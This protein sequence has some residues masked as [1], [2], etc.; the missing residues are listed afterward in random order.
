VLF[1][2]L[3]VGAGL[4]GATVAE[5]LA[6]KYHRRVLVIEARDHV[7]GHC[8]DELDETGTYVHK[9]GPHI[10][11]T[12]NQQVWDYLS[13][14]TDWHLYQH[15]VLA[16]I[17]GKKVPVPF[18]FESMEALFPREIALR[19]E[20]KLVERYGFNNKVAILD[21]QKENDADLNFLAD[22]VYKKVFEGYTIKQWGRKPEDLSPSVTGRVP[23]YIGYDSRY[24][25][26]RYQAI[27]QHGYT[28]MIKN[29]I[30]NPNITIV[31]KCNFSEICS[32]EQQK[33]YLLGQEF[34]GKVFYTGKIDELFNFVF[35]ELPYRSLDLVFETVEKRFFQ[36][37]ATVNYPSEYDFTR[38]TEFKHMS[39]TSD[40]D[41]TVILKE[42]P[43][44][45]RHG[46]NDAYY[47]FFTSEANEAY[48]KYLGLAKHVQDLVLVGRLAEYEYYDMDD[49]V[50]RALDAVEQA[51]QG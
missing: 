40:C 41:Q 8:Y 4:A 24:F 18:N 45:H 30:Q 14:F 50:A 1:D 47:P 26:D 22:F 2:N 7:G 49:V 43:V 3:V 9:Y 35:G 20:S 27:P 51:M 19:L 17:D 39:A 21:L 46:E 11:H 36:E 32:I 23:V 29:M 16:N 12:D 37:V 10:F 44:N 13:R 42:Y 38:I 33:I 25:Q 6:D 28:K 5:Q 48:S 15:R 34:K 31:L